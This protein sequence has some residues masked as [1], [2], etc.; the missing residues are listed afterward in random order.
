MAEERLHSSLGPSRAAQYRRCPGSVKA[1]EGLPDTA[2]IEAALGTVFHEFA[3]F[4]VEFGIDPHTMI[5]ATMDVGDFTGLEFTLEMASKMM[6]GLRLIGALCAEDP[7]S[8]L[9]VETR[10][11][12][13][14]WLGPDQFGTSDV[15]IVQ[16]TIRRM[17]VFDW[18]WGAG[19][20]V[21]PEKN[22]QA[23]LYALGCWDAHRALYG[24]DPAVDVQIIIEQP[25]APGG[26]GVW[27]TDMRDLL[28]EGEKIKADADATRDP[29]APRIP[30]P[31]QCQF[32][33][34]ARFNVCEEYSRY[35]LAAAGVKFD[36]LADDFAENKPLSLVDRRALT[37]EQRAQVLLHKAMIESYLS[38]LHEEAFADAEA[39]RPTPGQKLV[40]GRR[41]PRKW[42]DADKAAPI[43]RQM[44]G[45]EAYKTS[46]LSPAQVEDVLGADDY[47]ETF[48]AFVDQGEAK[49]ILVP[50]SDKRPARASH[51]DKFNMIEN[52]SLI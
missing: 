35:T 31:I 21:S 16:P 3:A 23:I 36:S 25:R 11:D 48:A 27:P 43:L 39:G 13:S 20:P 51:G 2:G 15:C 41:P 26:G 19:V 32:C 47:Q 52:E 37:P 28:A 29:D 22:D 30:G 38:R 10:L 24:G 9:F 40:D 5:G 49:P 45:K 33:A 46:L 1:Q 42:R 8:R 44:F 12:L 17:V 50:E 14:T 7:E 18:K 6:P 34:A 4:A